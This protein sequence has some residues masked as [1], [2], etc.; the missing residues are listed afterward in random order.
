MAVFSKEYLKW[1]IWAV[2]QREDPLQNSQI[3]SYLSCLTVTFY[4]KV[5]MQHLKCQQAV[6][7]LSNMVTHVRPNL[8]VFVCLLHTCQSFQLGVSYFLFLSPQFYNH[9]QWF[10]PRV[11]LRITP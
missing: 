2:V 1:T 11:T 7:V 8:N 4:F 6:Y 3:D 9:N 10:Y 5:L